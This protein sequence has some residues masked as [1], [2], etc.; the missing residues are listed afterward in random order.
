MQTGK[1]MIRNIFLVFILT[2]AVYGEDW[3]QWRGPYFNGS[4]TETNLPATWTTS[5]NV[6]W[7]ATLPG[8][9]GSTPIV[10]G[11]SVFITSQDGDSK[12]WAVGL[13]RKDGSIRW[14]HPIGKGFNNQQGNTAAS[15]S[16]IADD[17]KVYFLFGSGD[18]VGFD[19]NGNQLWKRNITQ[20]HGEYEI[21]WNYGSTGLLLQ[22]K[23][24][25]PVLHGHHRNTAPDK[26]Y[27]L[28][29]D[30]QTGKDLWKRDRHTDATYES[31]QA[32]T[33]PYPLEVSGK[34]Y[35]YITGGDYITAHD[36]KT[37][38]VLYRSE[39]HNPNN[40]RYGRTVVSPVS[41]DGVILQPAPRGGS[42]YAARLGA[43]G[44]ISK[45]L[46]IMR[47]N[48]PDVCTP[49]VYR[50]KFYILNGVGK[51]MLCVEP[52]SGRVLGE[53]DLEGKTKFQASPTGADGKIY[54]INMRG[55]AFVLSAA[56]TP[57][58]LHRTDMGGRD[59]RSSIAVAGGQLFIRVDD[60]LYCIGKK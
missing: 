19:K 5:Q 49:L 28:C 2:G 17:A 53:C 25:V 52:R 59:C 34:T 3:S 47:Q 11:D 45:W 14:K 26:S 33:T 35:I 55:E 10:R 58:I 13:N 12:T 41:V 6:V 43:Q 29:I 32:Y 38:K 56:D 57:R 15:P 31:K 18:F 46:W 4:T 54:C 22:D 16:P 37:G 39:T 1:K 24:Y 44:Q 40:I 51:K 9:G 20:D 48:S 7:I 30:P 21:L 60:R 8:G 36:P 27:L 42:I 23:I 50:G